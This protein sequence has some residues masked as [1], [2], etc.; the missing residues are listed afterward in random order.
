MKYR[1]LPRLAVAAAALALLGGMLQPLSA[2]STGA[3]RGQVIE[4]ATQHPLSGVQVFLQ[5]TTRGTVSDA[6]GNFLIPAV[7]AG[8]YNVQVQMIGYSRAEQQVTVTAEQTAQVSF[9]LSQAA[10]ELDALVVTGTPG[11]TQKRTLGNSMSNI[12]AAQIADAAPI[13]TVAQMLTGRTPGLTVMPSTGVVGAA[14]SIRIRGTASLSGGND[15]VFYVDGVRVRGGSQGGFGTSNHT[16]RETSPLDAINPDDI[17]SIE[18]IKGPAAATL[19]GADAANGVIQIITKKGQ[20]G[21]A[22]PI[23]WSGRVEMGQ[24]DWHLGM[25]E[26][27]TLCTN[28]TTEL[29]HVGMIRVNRITHADW[30]GCKEVDPNAPWQ[31]RLLRQT[32][33][34]EPGVLRKGEVMRYGL[35]AR[36]GGERFSYF[37]SGDRESEDGVFWNN[38]FERISGRANFSIIARDNLT[39]DFRV[40]YT[41]YDSRQPLNDNASFGW[42]RNSWRGRPG[43][44]NASSWEDGWAGLGPEMMKKYDN[45]VANERWILGATLDYRPFEWFRNRLTIGFDAGDRTNTLFYE[46]DETTRAPY[47]TDFRNGYISHF[48][49]ETRDYTVDYSGTINHDFARLGVTRDLTSAFSFGM[50]YS[51]Q[52]YRSTQVVGDGLVTNALRLIDATRTQRAYETITES[53]SLGFFVQEMLGWKNR[54]FVTGALRVDDHSAFGSNFEKIYY[55]KLSVAHVISEEPFFNVPMVDNLKLRFAYGHAGNAPAP[56]SADRVWEGASAIDASGAQVSAIIPTQYGNPDLRAERGR[57]FEF[58]F[59]ASLFENALGVEFTYYNNTTKDALMRDPIPQSSGFPAPDF[60]GTYLRNVGEISN[61]GTE[62]SLF[63]SPIRRQNIVWDTRFSFST[64]SNK[65]V[66]FGELK[67][68]FIAQ[69]YRGSQRHVEGYPLA[70]YFARELIRNPDGTLFIQANGQPQL[71]TIYKYVGPSAPTREASLTNT[72]TV[73]RNVQLYTHMDYK[74]GHYLFN[75]SEQTAL[76]DDLNHRMSNDPTVPLDTWLT[77]RY[78]DNL[79]YIEQADFIKL[80]EVSL[81]YTLSNDWARKVGADGLSFTLAG[82]NLAIPWTRYKSGVDPEVSI[83]GGGAFTRAE[84]NSVPMIRQLVATIDFRF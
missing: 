6:R 63:G 37:I 62:L 5:G 72:F 45:Q 53:R 18:V 22:Q 70:A 61:T 21:G 73:A 55:P 42:L 13:T 57:E 46:I 49:P 15:P 81:R 80:R 76:R 34:A 2:Q 43:F 69:G 64:N 66:S 71:D 12:N 29:P 1:S 77:Y 84:S 36:G 39:A 28:S 67:R 27:Y 58:G 52:N 24:N 9:Q 60:L 4:T 14:A 17:E 38:H 74:G 16:V 78:G 59:D 65:L 20:A 30:R 79:P 31:D 8:T 56:F 33:L 44:W 68:P 19:Y 25:R 32:P 41:T 11:A 47:G 51:A 23:R 10:I 82:R 48:E 26:N 54:L 75:M 50:Q 3:I 83:D 7:P 40:G 35:S